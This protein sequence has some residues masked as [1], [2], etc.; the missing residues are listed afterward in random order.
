MKIAELT[1]KEQEL[2]RS[3]KGMI[4]SCFTYGGAD[5]GS[6][7]FNKYILPYEAKLGTNLFNL[8]FNNHL[9]NLKLNY[10][11]LINTSTDCEGLT[12]NSLVKAEH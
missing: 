10:K 8:V 9:Q 6:Q 11:V 2:I 5:K 4:D 3:L 7:N 12:Y 1:P